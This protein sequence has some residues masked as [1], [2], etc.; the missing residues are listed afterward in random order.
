MMIL[1]NKQRV[2]SKSLLSIIPNN[3][4]GLLLSLLIL[5]L[6]MVG[7]EAFAQNA[8]QIKVRNENL[9]PFGNI[10]ISINGQQDIKIPSSGIAFSNL[11]DK[12]FPVKSIG[13]SDD[14]LEV[15]TWNFSKGILEMTIRKK[16]YIDT[17]I[18]LVDENGRPIIGQKILFNGSQKVNQVT[19]S[20][21]SFKV[22]LAINEKINGIDQFSIEGY[23]LVRLENS[24][25]LKLVVKKPEIIDDNNTLEELSSQVKSNTMDWDAFVRKNVP[26]IDSL[27]ALYQL[28]K[29][30]PLDQ[31]ND[32]SQKLIDDRFDYL[33]VK[34]QGGVNDDI[35]QNLNKI[36]DSTVIKQDI[37]YLLQEVRKDKK[38]LSSKAVVFEEKIQ[39]VRDKL[40]V[41]FEN[42]E[43]KEKDKLLSDILLLE[44]I[45]TENKNDFNENQD[46]YQAILNELKRRFFDLKEMESRLSKSEEER[47]REKKLSQ[48]RILAIL[49]VVLLF[50]LLILLLFILRARLKRQQT[51]LINANKQVQLVNENLEELVSERTQLLEQTFKELDLVLYRAS[52]D[53]RA[54]ICSIAGLSDLIERKTGNSELTDLILQTNKQMDRL[55]KKLSSISEIHQPGNFQNVSPYEIGQSVIGQFERKTTKYGIDVELIGDKD[56]KVSTIP[57]L[58]E[59]ILSNLLENA[60]NFSIVADKEGKKKVIIELSLENDQLKLKVSDFGIG[61]DQAIQPHIFDM[62]FIGTELSKGNGLGLYIVKKSVYVLNGT[63]KVSSEKDKFTNI[64]VAIP[65]NSDRH[66]LD[67]I[68]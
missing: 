57:L 17:E 49:G 31:I 22:P 54:P 32:R 50:A 43:A 1:N 21:G 65:I 19:N 47:L 7:N 30:V 8:V 28:L 52:H 55:L 59:V 13:L 29:Y 25:P 68:S 34:A 10:S 35:S 40:N 61:M 27:P 45:L 64:Q 5:L 20:K 24:V 16:N 18:L 3:S 12:E 41:G 66:Q 44:E 38:S 46:S 37:D 4:K 67:F 58:F 11:S 2:Q 56:L 42:L 39:L 62:F 63:I 48:R 33:I 60:L 36:N 26:S 51:Q 53:L 9:D 6:G 14:K 15:A 23:N